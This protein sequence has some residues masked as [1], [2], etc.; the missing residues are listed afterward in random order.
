MF[1]HFVFVFCK[2][3]KFMWLFSMTISVKIILIF[4]IN[5]KKNRKKLLK[6]QVIVFLDIEGGR[7]TRHRSKSA[8]NK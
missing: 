1:H 8:N 3:N 4:L 7:H 5:E 2:K 6:T